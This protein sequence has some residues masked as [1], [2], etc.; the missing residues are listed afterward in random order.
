ML[1]RVEMYEPVGAEA[2]GYLLVSAFGFFAALF[3]GLVARQ[4]YRR[5]RFEQGL[6]AF[7]PGFES[8]G[9]GQELSILTRGTSNQPQSMG[10]DYTN[11]H[12]DAVDPDLEPE[13]E[14][15]G[16]PTGL[17]DRLTSEPTMLEEPLVDT[18]QEQPRVVTRS[19]LERLYM[20]VASQ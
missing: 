20:W 2:Y 18:A 12:V 17:P 14:P 5:H 19:P 13:P 9:R 4:T 1:P 16:L 6:L 10:A 3:F 11:L 15:D 8:D 7:A